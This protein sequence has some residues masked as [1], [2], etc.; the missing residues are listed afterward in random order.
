MQVASDAAKSGDPVKRKH[1]RKIVQKARREFEAGKA[2][3]PTGNGQRRSEPAAN[4]ATTTK[5]KPLRCRPNGFG[6]RGAAAI[7]VYPLH[8]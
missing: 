6:D 4:A 5:R 2:V 7:D 3:L 8:S 1:S